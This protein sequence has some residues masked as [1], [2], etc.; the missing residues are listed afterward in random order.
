MLE[1]NLAFGT[2]LRESIETEEDRPCSLCE[3][4]ED[5]ILRTFMLAVRVSVP[6][7]FASHEFRCIRRTAILLHPALQVP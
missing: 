5:L 7:T 1:N 4:D 6:N 3:V 2:G